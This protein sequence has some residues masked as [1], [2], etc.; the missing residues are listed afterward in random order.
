[1]K[2][3]R[4][5]QVGRVVLPQD[6]RQELK[7]IEGDLLSFTRVDNGIFICKCI[8][9]CLVCGKEETLFSLRD[10]CYLCQDCAKGLFDKN[11]PKAF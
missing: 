5:D 2:R 11:P 4:L 3:K 10:D 7:W 9:S 1:M 6:L 8:P